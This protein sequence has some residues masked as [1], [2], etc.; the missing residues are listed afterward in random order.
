ME[1]VIAETHRF[2]ALAY[3]S[4][5]RQLQHEVRMREFV[6]PAGTRVFFD[7][8]AIMR[9]PDHWKAPEEFRPERFIDEEGKF[10]PDER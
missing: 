8:Y 1:A 4:V 6:L 3:L 2:S 5:P 10:R 7:L 9:D